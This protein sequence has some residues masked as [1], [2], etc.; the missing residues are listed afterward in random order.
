MAKGIIIGDSDNNENNDVDHTCHHRTKQTNGATPPAQN[1]KDFCF[2]KHP[3][4]YEILK[5][6]M[7]NRFLANFRYFQFEA[8]YACSC[9][10]VLLC[11]QAMHFISVI[12]ICKRHSHK[13]IVLGIYCS[14]HIFVENISIVCFKTS[15]H[16]MRKYLQKFKQEHIHQF[17]HDNRLWLKI[18]ISIQYFKIL[19]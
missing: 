12:A 2:P 14:Q 7:S 4:K 8:A 10:Q 9:I 16:Q 1:A 19:D 15:Y 5:S 11:K 18:G 3:H 17:A 13:E 6:T